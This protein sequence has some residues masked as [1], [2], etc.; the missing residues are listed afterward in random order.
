MS[1]LEKVKEIIEQKIKPGLMMDGG[2]IELI[3]LE[4]GIVK[5]KLQGSCAGCPMK[6]YTLVTFVESTLK[7]HVPEVK[8]VVSV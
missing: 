6:Q 8:Q 5:V 2:G 7:Q 3:G 4:D 1:T